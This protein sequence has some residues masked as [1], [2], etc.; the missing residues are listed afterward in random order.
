M[1]KYTPESAAALCGKKVKEIINFPATGE[2][3]VAFRTA[4]AKAKE[5]GYDV[6]SMSRDEPIA[7]ARNCEYIAK[8]YN[9]SHYEYPRIEGVLLSEDFRDGSVQLVIFE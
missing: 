2:T 3:F 4:E 7:F 1:S 5:L 8:W 9:I 6:G